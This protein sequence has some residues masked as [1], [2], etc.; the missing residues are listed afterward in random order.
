MLVSAPHISNRFSDPPQIQIEYLVRV[1]HNTQGINYEIYIFVHCLVYVMGALIFCRF[2]ICFTISTGFWTSISDH[3][4]VLERIAV[5][6]L[7]QSPYSNPFAVLNDTQLCVKCIR[8][9]IFA[10]CSTGYRAVIIDLSAFAYF[11]STWFFHP[12]R[13]AWWAVFFI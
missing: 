7:S 2:Y 13:L 3:A 1:R 6:T 8:F 4:A 12:N 11:L 10:T 9:V 5:I